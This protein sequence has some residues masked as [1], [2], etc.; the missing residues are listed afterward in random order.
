MEAE[1]IDL[2]LK[3]QL[4]CSGILFIPADI[5]LPCAISKSSAG[6]GAGSE[7]IVISFSGNRV[8]LPIS[9][10]GGDLTLQQSNSESY[11]ILKDGEILV[12]DVSIVPTLCHAPDQAFVCLGRSCIMGCAYCSMDPPDATRNNDLT[13]ESAFEMIRKEITRPEF[14]S[15]AITSGVSIDIDHQA[16]Q[17]ALLVAKLRKEFPDIPIG[18]EPLVTKRGHLVS[19][20][21]AGAN[22]VKINLEAARKDIFEKICPKRDYENTIESIKWAVEIFGRGSVS[23]NII[24]GMGE[25]D[26]D[27]KNALRMLADI[28]SVGNIRRLRTNSRNI[29][30]IIGALGDVIEVDS[31]RLISLAR[32]QNEILKEF[33]LTTKSFDTMC[34]TCGCCDLIPETDF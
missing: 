29:D 13:V 25:T 26:S 31:E 2:D 30:G 28:G 16:Q 21:E 24:I 14:H 23:S 10:N 6:P 5:K 32:L 17:I 7:S 8:K 18:V 27:V 12:S 3:A 20:K 22:E 33:S 19:L 4:I 34:F 11:D 9:R 15:V 1:T